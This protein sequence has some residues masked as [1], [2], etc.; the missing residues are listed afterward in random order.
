MTHLALLTNYSKDFATPDRAA[1]ATA[2][3][4]GVKVNN[5]L[6]AV[7]SDGKRLAS[8][9]EL[10]R[11]GGRAIGLITDAKLTDPT[12]AAFYAHSA[13]SSDTDNFARELVEGGN[14]DIAMGGGLAQFFPA[15]KGGERQ[16][17]HDLVLELRR[18]GKQFPRGADR[19]SSE[20][21]AAANLRSQ[22]K[23]KSEASNQVSPIWYVERLNYFNITRADICSSSMQD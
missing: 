17:G 15:T 4:T 12:S 16:D 7:D 23:S 10:A 2:I 8:I 14:I 1:A 19:N 3:A 11:A 9:V 5:R 13:D 22:T 6:I 20:V 18:N 21:S